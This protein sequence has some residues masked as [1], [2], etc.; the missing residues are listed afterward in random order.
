MKR[1]VAALIVVASL[2]V[3]AEAHAPVPSGDRSAPPPCGTARIRGRV[4][5]AATGRPVRL[6]TITLVPLGNGSGTRTA[7]TNVNGQYELADLHGGRYAFYAN[8]RG[9]LEQN[10][11]Q[12]RPLARYRLLE[13]AEGEHLDGI[14]FSLHRGGVITG[15]I[16]DESGDPLPDVRLTAV[17]HDTY[18]RHRRRHL[19]SGS[20]HIESVRRLGTR[21]VR[22]IDCAAVR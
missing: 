22:R 3:C 19:R 20:H 21:E 11:D 6:A 14:D 10:V 8:H 12:P 2:G 7:T 13:L 16:S 1:S 9:Y 5:A 17:R 15:I 18:R 4:V